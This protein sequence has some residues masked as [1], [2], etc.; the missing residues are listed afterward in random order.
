MEPSEP[1][2]YH[3]QVS[4]KKVKLTPKPSST[5]NQDL[6]HTPK[7]TFASKNK[8]SFFDNLSSKSRAAF[9]KHI[10]VEAEDIAPI[11]EEALKTTKELENQNIIFFKTPEPKKD[12]ISANV[13]QHKERTQQE[14]TTIKPK[15]SLRVDD[16]VTVKKDIG[17]KSRSALK[18]QNLIQEI[19]LASRKKAPKEEDFIKDQKPK[20][21][22][23]DDSERVKTLLKLN[24]LQSDCFDVIWNFDE[25]VI[26]AGPKNSGKTCLFELVVT[27]IFK[28]A[29][30]SSLDSLK[31]VYISSIKSNCQKCAQQ[32][33]PKFSKVGLNVLELTSWNQNPTELSIQRYNEASIII[34]TPEKWNSVPQFAKNIALL[35]IDDI[36]FLGNS[37]TFEAII[38]RTKAGSQYHKPR[39]IAI[40][41]ASIPN[42]CD[43]AEWLQVSKNCVKTFGEEYRSIPIEKHVLGYPDL[44]NE[45]LFERSL[46]PKLPEIIQEFSSGKQTLI[47]CQTQRSSIEACEQLVIEM[48]QDPIQSDLQSMKLKEAS[49][50]LADPALRQFILKGI[51]FYSF[52]LSYEDRKLIEELFADGFI[53]I[54]CTTLAFTLGSKLSAHLVIVKST[55]CYRHNPKGYCEYS[56]LEID[57][58]IGRA[59]RPKY[60]VKGIAVLMTSKNKLER[61]Q[62][63]E[64]ADLESHL[65]D[66]IF[67]VINDEISFGT[68]KDFGMIL[69][70]LKQTF[71]YVRLQKNPTRYGRTNLLE[72]AKKIV[73]E[74]YRAEMIQYDINTNTIRPSKLGLTVSSHSLSLFTIRNFLQKSSSNCEIQGLLR[75]LS[76]ARELKKIYYKL[77]EKKTLEDL[78]L[79]V[80]YPLQGPVSNSSKKCFILLQ[81]GIGEISLE[82]GELKRQTNEILNISSRILVCFKMCF[83][84]KQMGQ[85]YR[86]C[87]KLMKCI[88]LRS[89]DE[90]SLGSLALLKQIPGI[91]TKLIS[92]LFEAGLDSL[93]KLIKVAPQ[94]IENICQKNPP[95]GSQ[96]IRKAQQIPKLDV[97]FLHITSQQIKL[98]LFIASEEIASEKSGFEVIA[99]DVGG[100]IHFVQHLQLSH[101]DDINLCISELQVHMFPILLSFINTKYIGYDLKYLLY[102]DEQQIMKNLNKQMEKKEIL[103]RKWTILQQCSH[104]IN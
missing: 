10:K 70:Y 14:A 24:A 73:H 83:F 44:R 7:M 58:M 76:E 104:S 62:L 64:E 77:D 100:R 66:K 92:K 65:L 50:R 82:N 97:K 90:D 96:L 29:K 56:S 63:S 36:H 53:Q 40:S 34:T 101:G 11:H 49:T 8:A 18:Y 72:L 79:R 67:E 45:F 57:Q 99:E 78:N 98:H 20:P 74:L 61:P 3:Q 80:K 84:E 28:K 30:L 4:L 103:E 22:V 38:S 37:A 16:Q 88:S 71:F 59:G 21:Q 47:F 17:T 23:Q 81:V 43:F 41:S 86:S 75:L 26:I 102:S 94:E 93:E 33:K 54:I 5:K 6:Y 68:I 95:F 25:N 32:W 19:G 60:D 9:S 1:S 85:G 12:D 52:C 15:T 89:W 87:L 13:S 31:A 91:D 35:F 46:N 69:E 42:L 51:A 39:V 55:A 27:K 2:E 48:S